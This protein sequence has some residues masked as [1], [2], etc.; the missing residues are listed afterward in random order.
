MLSLGAI[1][2]TI[3]RLGWILLTE[4]ALV[5]LPRGARSDWAAT[6]WE[7]HAWHAGSA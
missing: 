3:G 6:D 7:A 1:P 5:R 4:G 2:R